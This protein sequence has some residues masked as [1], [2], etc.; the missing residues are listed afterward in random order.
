MQYNKY[1]SNKSFCLEMQLQNDAYKQ[2]QH[3]FTTTQTHHY[4]KMQ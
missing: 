2:I 4:N 1:L 3:F